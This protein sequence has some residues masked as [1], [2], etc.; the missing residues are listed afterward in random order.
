[1]KIFLLGEGQLTV[2]QAPVSEPVV[3]VIVFCNQW[4]GYL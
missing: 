4:E 1:M 2:A 3:G